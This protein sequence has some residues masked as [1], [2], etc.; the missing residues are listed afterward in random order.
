MPNPNYIFQQVDFTAG[1]PTSGFVV[2]QDIGFQ[3][4]AVAIDNYTAY[5]IFLRDAQAFIAP[6]WVGAIRVLLH[7]TTRAYAELLSPFTTEPQVPTD[8]SFFARFIWTDATDA[9]F[10]PGQS[11]YGGSGTP[12]I[13]VIGGGFVTEFLSTVVTVGVAAVVL[14]ATPLAN[15]KSMLV[16][17]AQDNTAVI[18]IGGST[19]TADQA[20]TGGIQLNPGQSMPI[21]TTATAIPYAISTAAAQKLIVLEGT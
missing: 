21:D 16:Q 11:I 5:Y 2:N 4:R 18:Y 3:A 17:A 9:P 20:A 1:P 10:T 19:V 15:R 7:T 14:P 6:Y 8:P 13:V 12:P